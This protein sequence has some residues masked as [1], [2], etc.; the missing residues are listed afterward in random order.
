ME[1]LAE[2]N[3][4][5][6]GECR[7]AIEHWAGIRG[8]YA[9]IKKYVDPRKVFCFSKSDLEW[10]APYGENDF[11]YLFAGIYNEK[12]IFIVA[13]VDSMG[14]VV[15]LPSYL[16]LTAAT[17]SEDLKLIE[18]INVQK[19]TT[20]TSNY[21]LL[22]NTSV[23]TNLNC[24]S[25]P[26]ISEEK[27]VTRLQSWLEQAMDWFYCECNDFSG[28]RIFKS[29][30]VPMFDLESGTNI[31]KVYCFFGFKETLIYNMLVP[32]ISFV[33]VDS[34]STQLNVQLNDKIEDGNLGDFSRPCPPF[35]GTKGVFPADTTSPS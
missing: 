19:V 9:E 28:Q 4:L 8:Q 12:M 11:F 35:C 29:F 1:Q 17:L 32:V 3:Q 2:T 33:A 6:I 27:F 18:K 5:S 14:N 23:T 20:L 31:N 7:T 10:L 24:E 16:Y 25:D 30:Q 34:E 13:P 15:V 26:S 21:T 22:N